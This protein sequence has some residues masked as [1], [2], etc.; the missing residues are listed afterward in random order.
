V[1]Y[2]QTENGFL[3]VNHERKDNLFFIQI[4]TR[5]PS[6]E[7]GR[8]NGDFNICAPFYLVHQ[9]WARSVNEI[10]EKI[11]NWGHS[12]DFD[13]KTYFEMWNTIDENNYKTIKDFH[14]T[15]PSLF[16]TLLYE[17][18]K[19]IP[20]LLQRM[21]FRDLIFLSSFELYVR[22]SRWFSRLKKIVNLITNIKKKQ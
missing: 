13:S 6:Y 15:T 8:R 17:H 1:L 4:A 2:K 12:D 22:N 7:F 11:K 10:R 3:Y 14:P 19:T 20:E 9:S 16:P 18:G 21:N 5:N